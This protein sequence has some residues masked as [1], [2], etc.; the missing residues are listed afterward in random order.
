MIRHAL[1]KIELAKLAIREV[2]VHL[3]AASALR[4][5]AEAVADH[6]HPDHRLRIDRGAVG[7]AVEGREELAQFAEVEETVDASWQMVS[8]DV[9]V[10][11]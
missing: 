7:V 10:K 3:F 4:A 6:Q 1:L 2:Q 9:V 11:G 8:G 5:D